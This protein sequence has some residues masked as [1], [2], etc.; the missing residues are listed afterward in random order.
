MSIVA[1]MPLKE[2]LHSAST[3]D[4]DNLDTLVT[5]SGTTESDGT[6]TDEPVGGCSANSFASASLTQELFTP[7]SSTVKPYFRTNRWVFTGQYA[8]GNLTNG[9]DVNVSVRCT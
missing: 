7:F 3:G 4:E 2:D 6:F 9:S 5:A 1:T 8:C